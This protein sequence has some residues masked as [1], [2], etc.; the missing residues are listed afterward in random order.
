MDRLKFQIIILAVVLSVSVSCGDKRSML[1]TLTE[2]TKTEIVL[3]EDL[4]VCAD[5][6]FRIADMSTLKPMK[7]IVYYDSTE[8][9]NCRISHIMELE[10]LY[11]LSKEDG[12][13]DVLII[14]SPADE[15]IETVRL[16]LMYQ[17]IPFPVY[18]DTFKTFSLMNSSIPQDIIFHSFMMDMDGKPVFVGNPT[19]DDVLNKVFEEV[20]Y[21][22]YI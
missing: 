20:L 4:E 16:Q 11:R 21:K 2:F 15:D 22:C 9:S 18:L 6:I 8:C 14:F 7:M 10:P 5:G 12:R 3:P 1:K 17:D 19:L 13:F